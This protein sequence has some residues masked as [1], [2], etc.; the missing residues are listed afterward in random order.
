MFKLPLLI[1]I[2]IL[3]LSVIRCSFYPKTEDATTCS[4]LCY[5]QSGCLPGT[6]CMN[7]LSNQVK[8]YKCIIL[9]YKNLKYLKKKEWHTANGAY[10][11]C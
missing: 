11:E 2:L 1:I 5:F 10:T 3:S 9:L 7:L 6:E 4:S 8:N